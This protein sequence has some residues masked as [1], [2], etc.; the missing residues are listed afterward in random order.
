MRPVRL[1]PRHVQLN[2]AGD[3]DLHLCAPDGRRQDLQLPTGV[4]QHVLGFGVTPFGEEAG[5]EQ[6]PGGAETPVVLPHRTPP[7]RH[8]PGGARPD[9]QPFAQQGLGARRLV[10]SPVESTRD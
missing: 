5:A 8:D 7:N 1:A 3:R 9:P 10:S 2:Q 6:A 4:E